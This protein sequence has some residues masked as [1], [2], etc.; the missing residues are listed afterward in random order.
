M[1]SLE[2]KNLVINKL[3]ENINNKVS[4][5]EHHIIK[6]QHGLNKKNQY[7]NN[8]IEYIKTN[9]NCSLSEI[10]EHITNNKLSKSSICK[11]LKENNLIKQRKK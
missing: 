5:K 9:N 1:Y 11:I 3:I 10:A 2:T 8:I 4:I 6:K 7:I